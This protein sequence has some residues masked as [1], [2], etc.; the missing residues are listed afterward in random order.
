MGLVGHRQSW[1]QA[2]VTSRRSWVPWGAPM[3]TEEARTY[4]NPTP[5]KP[6][7]GWRVRLQADLTLL[8]PWVAR[9]WLYSEF[10]PAELVDVS[11]S[12]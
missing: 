7:W 2:M 10:T 8:V 1:P 9:P 11:C 4:T 5:H 3:P 12:T 6:A